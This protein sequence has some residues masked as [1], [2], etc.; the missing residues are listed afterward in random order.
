MEQHLAK[1]GLVYLERMLDLPDV[2]ISKCWWFHPQYFAVIYM[3]GGVV[4]D[5]LR[6]RMGP[7]A[8][9]AALREYAK[10]FRFKPGGVPDFVRLCDKA[11]GKP[12][13]D[14][15][16]QWVDTEGFPH[17][18]IEKVESAATVK[19][20]VKQLAKSYAFDLAVVFEGEGKRHEQSFSLSKESEVLEA[21]VPF[22]V[23][24]VTLDPKGR[25]LKRPGPSNEWSRKSTE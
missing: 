16:D 24:K 4:F 21:A 19:V 12:T 8:F 5:M 10:E 11:C 23:E 25:L 18:K 20:T 6:R 22:K 17:L 14:L 9:A 2:A 1:A 7:P 15:F 13:K 3:K